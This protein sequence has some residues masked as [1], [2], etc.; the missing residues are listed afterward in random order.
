MKFKKGNSLRKGKSPWN[1]G[2]K[3]F[4][5]RGSLKKGH[6]D[7]VTKEARKQ[8]GQKTKGDKHWN[9]KGGHLN[10]LH[11]A[12]MYK[13]RR[14]GATGK[15]TLVEWE[16]LKA[17]YNW[18]CPCCR[19]KEPDIVLTEDHIIPLIK[20]GSDNIENIQPLCRSCNSKKHDKTIKY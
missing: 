12:K 10:D 2:M 16:T 11:L 4:F 18:T 15:H 6:E 20:G 17:Q 5:H 7:I 8:A 19:E 14:R 13:A 1:K 3:G 9:W